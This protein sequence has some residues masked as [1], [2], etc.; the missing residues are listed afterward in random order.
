MQDRA[1]PA[2][3]RSVSWSAAE[4]GLLGV[5]RPVRHAIIVGGGIGGLMCALA[6]SRRNIAATLYERD[7][8]PA[9]DVTVA[10]SLAWLRRGVPQALHP[11]FFM[12]RLRELLAA[13]YPDLVEA[14]KRAG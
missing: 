10:N 12:G 8:A 6:L 3:R 13:N 14:L 9:H 11:H 2:R 4:E 7:A 5:N 1:V